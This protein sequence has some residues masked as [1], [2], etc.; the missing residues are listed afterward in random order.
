MKPR[1]TH[2]ANHC[3]SLPGGTEDNDLW[4]R[5]ELDAERESVA[6]VSTW[7]PSD[8]ERRAIAGGEN[9]RLVIWSPAQPPVAVETTDEALGR[10]PRTAKLREA[11]EAIGCEIEEHPREPTPGGLPAYRPTHCGERLLYTNV[12]P[13]SG[14]DAVECG[15][16]GAEV[17]R[18]GI[19]D[20]YVVLLKEADGG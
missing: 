17:R 18:V 20:D 9:V 7:E 11:L 8:D 6:L 14:P 3:F 10:P 16:C 15:I 2:L 4:S 13:A 5:V 1:R 12:V 19:A